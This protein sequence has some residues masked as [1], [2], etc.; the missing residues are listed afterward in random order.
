MDLL[1]VG[2]A[3]YIASGRIVAIANP[4]SSPIKRLIRNA[5][6]K[7][8]LV[9]LTSGRRVKAVLVL[10]TQ[11]IVLVARQPETIAARANLATARL[12]AD[13]P[14]EDYV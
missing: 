4:G 6:E 8:L 5:E 3:N 9:D 2:F 12:G 11:H 14:E 10:D 13:A 1:P 7:G